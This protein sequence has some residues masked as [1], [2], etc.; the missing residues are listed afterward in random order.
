MHT[1]LSVLHVLYNNRL[2]AKIGFAHSS[3]LLRLSTCDGEEVDTSAKFTVSDK[4]LVGNRAY[5]NSFITRCRT[6]R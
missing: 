6:S 1:N 5:P 3:K 4:V 2:H